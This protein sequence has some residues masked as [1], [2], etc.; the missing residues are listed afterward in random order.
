MVAHHFA[1]AV[2]VQIAKLVARVVHAHLASLQD[3]AR[4]AVHEHSASFVA[5]DGALFEPREGPFSVH[6]HPRPQVAAVGAVPVARHHTPLHRALCSLLHFHSVERV[7]ADSAAAEQSLS[8]HNHPRPGA[9]RHRG[10]VQCRAAAHCHQNPR[11]V[12]PTHA[13]DV[14]VSELKR[15]SFLHAHRRPPHGSAVGRVAPQTH[16]EQTHADRSLTAATAA[17]LLCAAFPVGGRGWSLLLNPQNR[18]GVSDDRQRPPFPAHGADKL[19]ALIHHQGR[20]QHVHAGREEDVRVRRR[21]LHRFFNRLLVLWNPHALRPPAHLAHPPR[22]DR[23]K[24]SMSRRQLRE[25]A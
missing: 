17:A 2:H 25:H 7:V 6:R 8:K 22:R 12:A 16:A 1:A 24:V 3:P 5:L 13:L 4:P 23:R 18:S 9:T 20:R 19:Q 14:A 15:G 21:P 11:R 10:G